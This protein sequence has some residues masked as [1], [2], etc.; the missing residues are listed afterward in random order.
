MS[1]IR[2]R[3]HKRG[4][5]FLII[6]F[7]LALLAIIILR[8]CSDKK[9]DLSTPD[10]RQHFLADLGWEIDPASEEHKTVRIPDSLGEIIENY[11]EIQ[12]KQGYDLQKHLGETCEQY[13]YTVLNYPDTDQIVQITLYVQGKSA[14][15]GDIHS[16]A[17]NGFMAGLE[18]P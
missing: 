16:T 2:K 5:G 11:N 10:G 9:A 14:I 13:T 6:L 4:L 18:R 1:N 17:L 3:I 15:A 12:L 7:L 8:S